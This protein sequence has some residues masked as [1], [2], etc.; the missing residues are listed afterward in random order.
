MVKLK[1]SSKILNRQYKILHIEFLLSISDK[2]SRKTRIKDGYVLIK[3]SKIEE[4][5]KYNY[6]NKFGRGIIRECGENL[7]IIGSN[8]NSNSKNRRSQIYG[9]MLLGFVKTH[10]HDRIVYTICQN[11]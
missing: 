5:G 7:Q 2:I 4:A 10:G 8:K 6:N 3:R 11:G 1:L 9:I